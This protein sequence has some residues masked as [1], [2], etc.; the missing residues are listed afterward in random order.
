MD[1]MMKLKRNRR[2]LERRPEKVYSKLALSMG[3]QTYP[4]V[5]FEIV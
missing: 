4:R 2:F 5:D 3:R 1:Q